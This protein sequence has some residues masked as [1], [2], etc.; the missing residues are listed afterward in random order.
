M[1]DISAQK[2]TPK[3]LEKIQERAPRF[4]YDDFNSGYDELLI[5]ANIPSLYIRRLRTMA[6]ETCKILNM[7]SPPVLYDLVKL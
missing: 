7:L 4:V 3:K 5:K 6:I 1:H 2:R